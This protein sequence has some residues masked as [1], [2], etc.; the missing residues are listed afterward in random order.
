MRDFSKCK[1]F[2]CG[3]LQN[4]KISPATR[5]KTSH[6]S[7]AVRFKTQKNSLLRSSKRKNFVCRA[8]RNVK[9]I[10]TSVLKR[11]IFSSAVRFNTQKTFSLRHSFLKILIIPPAA[12]FKTQKFRLRRASKL[13]ICRAVRQINDP[14]ARQ[15]NE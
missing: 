1:I 8:L 15:I 6:V 11:P 13:H 3:A 10:A 5:F 7:F 2:A 9:N 4:V 12:H 14:R